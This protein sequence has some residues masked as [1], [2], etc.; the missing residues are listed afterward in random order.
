L[1]RDGG[2]LRGYAEI[3]RDITDRRQAAAQREALIREQAARAEAEAAT[4]MRDEFLSIAAHELK[5]PLT[6][7]L[8]PMQLVLRLLEEGPELDAVALRRRLAQI[9]RQ[10]AKLARMV[11]TL[12][13]L[14]RMK[15]GRLELQR[16]LVDLAPLVTGAVDSARLQTDQHAFVL[17]APATLIAMVDAL[18]L[19]QVLTNLLD[20]AIKYSPDGGP[21]EI[22]LGIS[23]PDSVR[24][25][26]RDHGLGIP[27]EMRARV[28]EQFFRA[29]GAD[30]RSGMGIGLYVSQQIVDQHFGQITVESPVDGGTR[31][32]VVLPIGTN[33]SGDSSQPNSAPT[34]SLAEQSV[35]ES[36]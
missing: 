3:I 5:T 31:V 29:H 24:L 22:E 19:E 28:F 33:P 8:A 7:I 20:N 18:R 27:P 4:K 6:T 13:D 14:S 32:L 23:S 9:A 15:S 25:T 26:V 16:E 34:A 35:T 21:I 1:R 12:L 2:Q 36:R 11:D 17:V 10:A 30:Y